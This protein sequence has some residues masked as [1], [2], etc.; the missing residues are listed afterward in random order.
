MCSGLRCQVGVGPLTRELDCSG[1]WSTIQAQLQ[2]QLK[3]DWVRKLAVLKT[4]TCAHV[5]LYR[6]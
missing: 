3:E 1:D 5:E 6:N 4:G 2:Q